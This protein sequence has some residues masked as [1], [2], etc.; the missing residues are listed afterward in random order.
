MAD[1]LGNLGCAGPDQ[2]GYCSEACALNFVKKLSQNPRKPV[3][4]ASDDTTAEHRPVA[5]GRGSS[6]HACRSAPARPGT[7]STRP[8]SAPPPTAAACA[9]AS[10]G[11]A[12]SPPRPGGCA[13]CSGAAPPPPDWARCYTPRPGTG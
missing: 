5:A 11:T 12:P 6:P 8:A 13:P 9:S 3:G 7:C 10:C 4:D 1:N 2:C